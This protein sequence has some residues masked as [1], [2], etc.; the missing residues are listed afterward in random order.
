MHAHTVRE[1]TGKRDA[2]LKWLEEKKPKV[3]GGRT[4][5][6]TGPGKCR[7]KD[8]KKTAKKHTY[9]SKGGDSR[10]AE[11]KES[12]GKYNPGEPW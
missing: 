4:K 9:F 5:M 1:E 12:T 11:R 6:E 8:E 7:Q 2:V 10:E 3:R